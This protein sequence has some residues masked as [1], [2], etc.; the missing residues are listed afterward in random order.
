M[1]SGAIGVSAL[2]ALR[3]GYLTVSIEVVVGSLDP[4][5]QS[6]VVDNLIRKAVRGIHL[7]VHSVYVDV[8]SGH[9]FGSNEIPGHGSVQGSLLHYRLRIEGVECECLSLCQAI[10]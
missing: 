2:E 1:D 3:N 10:F 8:L 7:A 5:K 4:G 9:F 6:E